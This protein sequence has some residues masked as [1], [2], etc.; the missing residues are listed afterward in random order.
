MS[1]LS[2]RPNPDKVDTLIDTNLAAGEY[3]I[4]YSCALPG[5][6]NIYRLEAGSE[7]AVKKMVVK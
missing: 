5:G 2:K 7:S 4:D 1:I 6:I 3:E